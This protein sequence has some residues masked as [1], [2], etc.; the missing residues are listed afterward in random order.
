MKIA[1]SS[2]EALIPSLT[3][4]VKIL[5]PNITA[6]SWCVLTSSPQR[7][8]GVSSLACELRYTILDIDPFSGVP[9]KFSAESDDTLQQYV[10]EL[11][12]IEIR[13]TYYFSRS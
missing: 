4:P 7:I 12:D 1:E 10:E 8:D 11:H 13:H 9:L 2:D 5:L 3:V 6:V